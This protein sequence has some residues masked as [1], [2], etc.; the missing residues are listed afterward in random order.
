MN[1]ICSVLIHKVAQSKMG[2]YHLITMQEERRFLAS[3]S[4]VHYIGWWVMET[5]KVPLHAQIIG[6]FYKMEKDQETEI[7]IIS[8]LKNKKSHSVYCKKYLKQCIPENSKWKQ[9]KMFYWRNASIRGLAAPVWNS[10]LFPKLNLSPTLTPP[11]HRPLPLFRSH[12]PRENLFSLF[13][14]SQSIASFF[15]LQ[16]FAAQLK[17]TDVAANPAVE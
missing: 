17:R 3:C 9:F 11:V 10:L 5:S 14:A 7:W 1:D 13:K 16:G 12:P 4:Y 2:F 8:D 6:V 15:H